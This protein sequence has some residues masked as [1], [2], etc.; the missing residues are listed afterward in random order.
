MTMSRGVGP[1]SPLSPTITLMRP[2]SRDSGSAFG[3]SWT[4]VS[5]T[6]KAASTTELRMCPMLREIRLNRE[7]W[8]DVRPDAVRLETRAFRE[9]VAAALERGLAAFLQASDRDGG[10]AFHPPSPRS[11]HRGEPQ[12]PTALTRPA[13]RLPTGCYSAV[14][15]V[16]S[17]R[18]GAP[19]AE[20]LGSR[21]SR[22]DFQAVRVCA[23]A[24]LVE[25]R[26]GG[27]DRD[28]AHVHV[29]PVANPDDVPQQP[30][31]P[32]DTVSSRCREQ[33]H[34]RADR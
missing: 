23:P 16:R 28:Q 33:P 8:V 27:T 34:A 7:L 30:P 20:P 2:S 22:E 25:V 29:H 1:T 4:T 15:G 9:R 6:M 12:T 17:L 24:A 10:R 14:R 19:E 13:R 32:V 11:P 31:V 21:S 3:P 18:A 26:R 5:A